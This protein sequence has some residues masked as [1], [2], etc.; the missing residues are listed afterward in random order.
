MDNEINE[1]VNSEDTKLSTLHKFIGGLILAST[2][3]M[4]GTANLSEIFAL[5]QEIID[6]TDV[7]IGMV[8]MGVTISIAVFI[9]VWIKKLLSKTIN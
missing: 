9:G 2:L 6:N 4:I 5:M 3:L 1:L 7:I 8:I